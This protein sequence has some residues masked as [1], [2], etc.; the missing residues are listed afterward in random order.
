[1]KVGFIAASDDHSSRPGLTYP[2]GGMTTRGG[3]TGV[4]AKELT[5]ESLWEAIWAR[6]VYGS[7]S[8]RIIIHID[9]DGHLMGEEYIGEKAPDIKVR[10]NGTASILEVEVFNWENRIY[11]HPFA[12]PINED[13]KLFKVEWSGARVR[14]RPKVVTWNGGLTVKNGTIE[15]YKEFG[16]DYPH[17]GIEKISDTDLNWVSTTGGDLD[18]V[19]M[20]LDY[21]D[22]TVIEFKTKPINFSFKPLEV[23]YEPMIVDAGGL[24]QKVKVS[25]IKKELPKN[26]E[27]TYT[28]EPSKGLNAFWVRLVQADSSM[29]WTSPIFFNFNV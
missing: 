3:Y 27:F 15:S 18:G 29:A 25:T 23:K 20:K 4:Y 5:R 14:S 28:P 10:I 16:F 19:L 6:R 26:L 17:Q 9:S 22:E 8:E 2:S 13:E 12:E 11:R 7:T 1:M 21:T 24:N